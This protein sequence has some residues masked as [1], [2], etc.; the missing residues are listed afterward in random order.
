MLFKGCVMVRSKGFTLVE[1]LV[2]IAIIGVLIGLLLPAVQ[3]ARES[4]RRSAC[5]NHLKQWGLA[6]HLH[7]DAKRVLPHGNSRANPPGTENP[8]VPSTAYRPFIISLWPFLE[9]D[10]LFTAYDL[11]RDTLSPGVNASGRSNVSLLTTADAYFCPSDRPGST[12]GNALRRSRVNY[13]VNWGPTTAQPVAG[14]NATK[15]APFGH[16]TRG[17]SGTLLLTSF[18]PWQSKWSE[19][20]D[21][22][23][24]TLLMSEIR[25]AAADAA[26]FDDPRGDVFKDVGTFYF[27]TANTPN[28]GIDLHPWIGVKDPSLADAS[29]T[30]MGIVARS[31]H[32][33]GVNAVMCDGSTVFIPNTISL[34]IW[35]G[36]GTMN[37]N[38]S[39]SLP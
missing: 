9:Q 32:P 15:R 1:L 38:E 34:A 10:S 11:A 6:M 2:V 17:G 28:S 8:A 20:T 26:Y 39:V 37:Q 4:A 13:V 18:V 5:S 35:S 30:G 24:K 25:I 27:S 22:L 23:S 12:T 33:G 7:H 16:L 14:I 19:M 36:L 3:A 29:S 31:Q 21:G